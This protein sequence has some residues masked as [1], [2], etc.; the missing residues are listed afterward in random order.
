MLERILFFFG[1]NYESLSIQL[2]AMQLHLFGIFH[3]SR[4]PE[5]TRSLSAI[6]F[7][8]FYLHPKLVPNCALRATALRIACMLIQTR[9][10]S[11]QRNRIGVRNI[12]VYQI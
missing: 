5:T 1:G 2:L 9:P 8:F 7:V 10:H 11:Y 4:L 6:T 3:Q 12:T